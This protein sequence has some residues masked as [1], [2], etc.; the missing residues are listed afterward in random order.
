MEVAGLAIRVVGLA[1]LFDTC[2]GV[3]DRLKNY[4][5]VGRDVHYLSTRVRAEKLCF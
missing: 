1:A 5:D 3:F 4:K 2:L